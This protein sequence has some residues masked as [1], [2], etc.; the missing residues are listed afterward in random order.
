M[1][2]DIFS[3]HFYIK[4]TNIKN[5]LWV[6]QTFNYEIWC[7]FFLML[8]ILSVSGYFKE[9]ISIK[10]LGTS[11]KFVIKRLQDY[12]FFTMRIASNQGT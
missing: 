5:K 2:N 11:K 8:I 12:L 9:R 4:P 7:I 1:F 6:L 3:S 10:Y